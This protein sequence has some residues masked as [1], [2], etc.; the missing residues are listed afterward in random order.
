MPSWRFSW[1]GTWSLPCSSG[2]YRL[3]MG[4]WT[5]SWVGQPPWPWPSSLRSAPCKGYFYGLWVCCACG[6]RRSVARLWIAAA[7]ATTVVHFHRLQ[8]RTHQQCRQLLFPP[9]LLGGAIRLPVYRG[10][11]HSLISGPLFSLVSLSLACRFPPFR[12]LAGVV[13]FLTVAYAVV[14][15]V[16]RREL[17]PITLIAFAALFDALVLLG[18]ACT[19]AMGG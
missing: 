3:R 7:I 19:P 10:R 4:R 9:N 8:Q 13:I 6:G 1:R 17:F 11:S 15:A 14:R 2:C 18:F 16:Q 12:Q 5:S